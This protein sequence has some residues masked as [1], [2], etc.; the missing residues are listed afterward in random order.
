MTRV[1]NPEK[2]RPPSSSLSHLPSLTLP[3]RKPPGSAV[4]K[5]SAALEARPDEQLCQNFSYVHYRVQ[6]N[7]PKALNG[8]LHLLIYKLAFG[9]GTVGLSHSFLSSFH[10]L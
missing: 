7:R 1:T 3:A 2:T 5:F 9:D 6:L 10:P 4:F 8:S